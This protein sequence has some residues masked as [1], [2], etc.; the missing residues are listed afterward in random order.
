[1]ENSQIKKES[2]WSRNKLIL[3]LTFIFFLILILMIPNSMVSS[4]VRERQSLSFQTKRE[5]AESWGPRQMISTPILMIPIDKTSIVDGK[6]SV[7][8]KNMFLTPEKVDINVNL[9][10][11]IRKKSI[12]EVLLYDA[13]I[14][15][16][17]KFDL[18]SLPTVENEVYILDEAKLY[19][20]FT[21]PSTISTDIKAQVDN[22]EISF[23]SGGNS[24]LGSEKAIH[25]NLSLSPK[26]QFTFDIDISI[27]GHEQFTFNPTAKSTTVNIQSDWHSPSFIGS[28]YPKNR[29]ISESG[30]TSEYHCTEYKRSVPDYWYDN[31]HQPY[32]SNYENKHP[33]VKLIQPVD[34]YQKNQRTSKYALLILSLTFISFYLFEVFK[35]TKTH[36][37]QYTFIGFALVLFYALLL[38]FTEHIGF[39]RAYIVSG[40][41]TIALISFYSYANF[42]DMKSTAILSGVLSLLYSY[43]FILL[44]LENYALLAG[45]I[46]LFVILA[47]IMYITRKIDWYQLNM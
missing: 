41:A 45:C 12:Y 23:V 9:P 47:T 11:Q 37:I 35:N 26:K 6:K 27:L 28:P 32:T 24:Y 42:K 13:N 31:A 39:S 14:K 16:D 17:G 33:G 3:K 4:L 7:Y 15:I 25:A 21:D 19:L 36:P 46:G 44:R 22:E 30:F 5:I 8:K 2:F 29:D 38:S 34:H 10:T 18:E 43:I 20:G 1:M 40:V